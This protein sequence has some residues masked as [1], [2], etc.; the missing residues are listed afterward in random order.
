MS[1]KYIN[2]N[3]PLNAA[4]DDDED[5]CQTCGGTGRL[6]HPAT[7]KPGKVCPGCGGSG[8]APPVPEEEEPEARAAR[9]LNGQPW[10]RSWSHLLAALTDKQDRKGAK[11]FIRNAEMSERI[12]SE[13]GFTVPEILANELLSYVSEGIIWPRATVLPMS[14]LRLPVP[15]MEDLSQASGAQAL[16]G[17]KFSMVGEGDA[18]PVTAPEFGRLALEARKY[19]GYLESVPNE[20]LADA[21]DAMGTLLG[22]ILGEGWAWYAD[23]LMISQGDGVGAPQAL[24]AAPGALAVDRLASDVVGVTD[25]ANMMKALHPKAERGDAVWLV[26]DQVFSTLL[27]LSLGV[28]ETPAAGYVPASEWLKFDEANGCWR[29]LGLEC[30]PHDHL[31]A[32]GS[33]GDVILADLSQYLIGSREVLTVDLAA[34]GDGFITDTTDIR[35]RSRIDA[36]WWPQ[37]AFTTAA[38]A[39]VSPLVVLSATTS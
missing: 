24:L 34:S 11:A 5:Q 3:R 29:L 10:A 35:I 14:T 7:G 19:G 25:L 8:V 4:P 33:T 6:K 38:G 23:D 31:P 1:R 39:T 9:A 30:I 17:L 21:S 16:A 27:E 22:R 26:A 18:Y 36:R 15:Y 20:L 13:G 28:G 12:P 32:I 2:P 37:S